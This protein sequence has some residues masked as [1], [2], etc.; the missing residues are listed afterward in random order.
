VKL[1][2]GRYAC[3]SRNRHKATAVHSTHFTAAGAYRAARTRNTTRTT[4]HETPR[5]EVEPMD[6]AP[7]TRRLMR[8]TDVMCAARAGTTA[9]EI[10][11]VTAM[12]P[13]C[14]SDMLLYLARFGWVR[15][16]VR[17]PGEPTLWVWHPGQALPDL[18]E[19]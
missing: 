6:L 2:P 3:V 5:L 19:Q 11:A 13:E 4:W 9:A 14:I 15:A 16:V 7:R 12:S 10:S 18:P 8:L 17:G 1:L